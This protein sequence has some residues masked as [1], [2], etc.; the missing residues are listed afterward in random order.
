MGITIQNK[1]E[2]GIGVPIRKEDV[3]IQRAA[4]WAPGVA[5]DTSDLERFLDDKKGHIKNGLIINSIRFPGLSDDIVT[6]TANSLYKIVKGILAS[7]ED[8]EKLKAEPIRRIYMATESTNDKS[9]PPIEQAIE[10]VASKLLAEGESNRWIADML[11]SAAVAGVFYACRG[12]A[13][14]LNDAVANVKNSLHSFDHNG[15]PRVTS[16]LLVTSDIA[17]YNPAKAQKAEATQGSASTSMWITVDPKLERIAI[18]DGVGYYHDAFA[19]FTKYGSS[20]PYVPSGHFSEE[21]FVYICS[22]AIR[23]FEKEYLAIHGEPINLYSLDFYTA[24]VPHPKQPK[25]F[26]SPLILHLM[27]IYKPEELN[28]II[29]EIGSEPYPNFNGFTDMLKKKIEAFNTDGS[30][31]KE[32]WEIREALSKDSELNGYW[33]WLKA[34]RNVGAVEAKMNELHLNEAVSI[35]RETGNTYTNAVF[36][37]NIA[38]IK[39]FAE[40]PDIVA[41][42]LNQGKETIDGILLSYGS[43]AGADAFLVKIPAKS[44]VEGGMGERIDIDIDGSVF[45]TDYSQ[46]RAFHEAAMQEDSISKVIP[47][48]MDLVAEDMKLLRTDKLK[49]GFHVNLMKATGEGA[50][51]Y[52]NKDGKIE[53]VIIRH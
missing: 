20:N 41:E 6:L 35:N 2:S 21:L 29:S 16:A 40:H 26:A 5:I 17:V 28:K 9:R 12:G 33:D 37:S 7:K 8:T 34:F 27:R 42:K 43:G 3:G 52:V 19:D 44:V 45:I 51:S 22:M 47:E 30:G 11:R 49:E 15:N 39:Y 25:M 13:F 48:N 14:S 31:F 36:I 23:N 1:S 32:E 4:I 50:W 24:H 53:K 38:V 46:Y 18:E 10:L